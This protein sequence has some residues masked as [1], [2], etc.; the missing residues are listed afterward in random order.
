MKKDNI[1]MEIEVGG[2]RIKI[3]VKEARSLYENLKDIFEA[4]LLTSTWSGDYTPRTIFTHI[5]PINK[6]DYTMP[7]TP[8]TGDPPTPQTT[9]ICKATNE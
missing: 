3:T 1:K 7:P 4:P 2:K 9:T 6:D 5:T 8:T